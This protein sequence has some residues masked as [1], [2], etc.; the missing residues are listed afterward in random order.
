[1][2]PWAG[3]ENSGTQHMYKSINKVSRG[4]DK[5]MTGCMLIQS[6]LKYASNVCN[7]HK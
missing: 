3:L 7:M 6:T 1:M 4:P 2:Q 5:A